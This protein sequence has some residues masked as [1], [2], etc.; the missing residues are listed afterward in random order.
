MTEIILADDD[1]LMRTLCA[2]WLATAGYRV[3]EAENGTQALELLGATPV[4]VLITD[5]D[6]PG[7][8]GTQTLREA[9]RR[10]PGL[11]VIAISG[12]NRGSGRN[13]AAAALEQGAAKTLAKPFTREAL[14]AAVRQVLPPE[15]SCADQ[16]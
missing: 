7:C 2:E 13:W 4:T 14:L 15:S 8:D 1:A 9:R 11:V 3:R 12:G 5:M 6:M 10:R 16:A